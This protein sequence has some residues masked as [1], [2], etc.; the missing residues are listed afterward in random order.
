VRGL[1]RWG[2]PRAPPR[3]GVSCRGAGCAAATRPDLVRRGEPPRTRSAARARSARRPGLFAGRLAG[4]GA[5]RKLRCTR[6]ARLRPAGRAV[7]LRK[8][9]PGRDR[10]TVPASAARHR[11]TSTWAEWSLGRGG[12]LPQRSAGSFETFQETR[13]GSHSSP[14]LGNSPEGGYK[15]S[16]GRRAA[17]LHDEWHWGQSGRARLGSP[18]RSGRVRGAAHRTPNEH[19]HLRRCAR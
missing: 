19:G 4:L 13:R 5:A 11:P 14:R 1:L 8:T 10:T 15:R 16:E 7:T 3:S 6:K 18:R 9:S 17:L 12:S 2:G